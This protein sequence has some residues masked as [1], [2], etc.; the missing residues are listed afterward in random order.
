[1]E[2]YARRRQSNRRALGPGQLR[3]CCRKFHLGTTS[4]GPRLWLNGRLFESS[5]MQA[6]AGAG[7]ESER[8]RVES[9][10]PGVLHEARGSRGRDGHLSSITR[11]V[12]GAAVL[13]IGSR[14]AARDASRTRGDGR[15]TSSP[16]EAR[17][18]DRVPRRRHRPPDTLDALWER[19]Q[20]SP[21]TGGFNSDSACARRPDD[22]IVV[23]MRIGR[24]AAMETNL[25]PP[26]LRQRLG[27]EATAALADL[28]N[29]ART[30]WTG[31]MLASSE[32]ASNAG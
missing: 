14:A 29:R 10:E 17:A 22:G 7:Q 8:G 24:S 19:S 5:R 23:F 21:P 9:G 31:E 2:V 6:V 27:P 32:I 28:L 13:S 16:A 30:E 20:P 11:V 18:P 1:M 3:A 26:A 15:S 12:A 4:R 25:V